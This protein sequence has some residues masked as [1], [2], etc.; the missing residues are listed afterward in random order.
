MSNEFANWP[1]LAKLW[2]AEARVVSP[3]EVERRES[4]QRRQMQALAG[5]EAAALA[6]VFITAVWIAM[7]T[8]LI[9]LSAVSMTFFGFCAYLQHRMRREPPPAGD[10]DLMTSLEASVVRE[11]WVLAQLGVGRAVTLLTLAAIAMVGSNHL[12]FLSST[13]PE[14]LWAMLAITLIVLA[15]LGWNLV[16]TYQAKRRRAGLLDYTRHLRA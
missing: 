7:H 3:D 9:A 16:L 4:R 1:E 13:P 10:H 8:A 5:A 15:I 12:R 14:R 2:H 11:N 6:L